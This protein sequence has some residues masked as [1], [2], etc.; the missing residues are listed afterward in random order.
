MFVYHRNEEKLRTNFN[1]EIDEIKRKYEQSV[2]KQEEKL[3]YELQQI[4]KLSVEKKLSH[5]NEKQKVCLLTRRITS[6]N[7]IFFFIVNQ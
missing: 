3:K 6:A 1:K 5:E 4:D 7:F 2:E